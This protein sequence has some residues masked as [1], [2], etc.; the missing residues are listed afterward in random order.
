MPAPSWKTCCAKSGR[1][2]STREAEERR[3]RGEHDERDEA[4]VMPHVGQADPAARRACRPRLAGGM[5]FTCSD[6]S[7]LMTTRNESALSR[8]QAFIACGSL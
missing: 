8:K 6:I 3:R 5:C 2:V 4:A 1:N 7:V